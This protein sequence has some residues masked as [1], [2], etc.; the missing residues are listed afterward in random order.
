VSV[1]YFKKFKKNIEFIGIEVGG[2]DYSSMI[3]KHEALIDS[4]TSFILLDTSIL[5]KSFFL[6]KIQLKSELYEELWDDYFHKFCHLL[7]DALYCT[8]DANT[9]KLYPEITFYSRGVSFTLQGK[10][11]KIF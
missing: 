1:V 5:N 3:V 9:L 6:K 11:K 8:C 10:G 2:V 4:G 7:S